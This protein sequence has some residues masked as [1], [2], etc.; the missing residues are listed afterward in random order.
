MA[1]GTREWSA[2]SDWILAGKR[3][4]QNDVQRDDRHGSVLPQES[5]DSTGSENYAQDLRGYH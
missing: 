4:K 2:G 1:T 3:E 5:I